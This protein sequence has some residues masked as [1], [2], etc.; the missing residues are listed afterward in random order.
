M[1]LLCPNCGKMLTVPDQY[2]GQMMKCRLCS[3]PFTVPALPGGGPQEPAPV[4]PPALPTSSPADPYQVRHDVSSEPVPAFQ[5][6]APA[7]PAFSTA[8]PPPEPAFQTAPS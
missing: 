1:N 6:Q 4:Q 8:P 3:G 5:Q 7:E 2:A